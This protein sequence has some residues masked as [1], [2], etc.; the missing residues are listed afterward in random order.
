MKPSIDYETG[1]AAAKNVI[2]L[3]SSACE[4]IEIA[5][6]LRRECEIVHDVDLVIW[7]KSNPICTTTSLFEFEQQ[8]IFVPSILRSAL[9][10]YANFPDEAKIIRFEMQGVPVELYL[11]EPDGNNFEALWQMRTGSA[12]H[13]RNLASMARRKYLN[14]RAG[15]GIYRGNY[16]M[17]D[18]SEQ[19]IY[20]ALGMAYPK[21][22]SRDR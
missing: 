11:C 3:I 5:G 21:P 18:G 8:L 16:R 14:Y 17:D 1:L 10:G 9:I 19:G 22:E 2:T 15:Y 20:K 6:S 4:R 13:N 7:P 12:V